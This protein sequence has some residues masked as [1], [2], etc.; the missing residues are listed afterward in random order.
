[1]LT[2]VDVNVA[3]PGGITHRSA[4][5]VIRELPAVVAVDSQQLVHVLTAAPLG[6]AVGDEESHHVAGALERR[7][8]VGDERGRGA[9]LGPTRERVARGARRA[10][11]CTVRLASDEDR[12]AAGPV[13]QLEGG[14]VGAGARAGAGAEGGHRG[15]VEGEQEEEP[16]TG[17]P[18]RPADLQRQAQCYQW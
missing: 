14:V 11:V 15:Q 5:H 18:P 7:H 9:V 16:A 4:R 17:H 10:G 8:D 13:R 3:D 2:V 6:L 12:D 1:M